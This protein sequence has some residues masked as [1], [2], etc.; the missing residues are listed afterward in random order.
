MLEGAGVESRR[1]DRFIAEPSFELSL[2]G[3]SVRSLA[4]LEAWRA[5]L[6]STHLELG[7]RIDSVDVQPVGEDVHRARFEFERRA[8]DD[9]GFP[10]I[11]RREHTWL[12]RNVP[13]EAPVTINR[14]DQQRYL[15]I[16]ADVEDRDLGSV[17][18]DLVSEPDSGTGV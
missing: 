18:G 16:V 8:V 2:I 15:R 7:Y 14:L 1:L 9:G 3:G 6:H 11:A 12:V 13:G 5:N 4:E 10:H 17:V